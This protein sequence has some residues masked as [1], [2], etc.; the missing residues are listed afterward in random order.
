MV[1]EG[2]QS[3]FG[4]RQLFSDAGVLSR[5]CAQAY[6]GGH[7]VV[8]IDDVYTHDGQVRKS[9]VDSQIRDELFAS[10][11]PIYKERT[12][13]APDYKNNEMWVCFVSLDN[14]SDAFVDKAFVWNWRTNT[15]SKRDIPNLSYIGWGTTDTTDSSDWVSS[16][17]W[18][19][20]SEPWNSPIRQQMLFADVNNSK[21]YLQ[22]DTN[23][24]DG[25]NFKS[26]AAKEDMSLGTS[27]TKSVSKLIPRVSGTGNVNFYVGHK[28]VPN[29]ATT[30]KGPY[31]FTPGTHSEISVRATG[32]Y[33]GV[34]IETEDNN[35]WALDNLEVHWSTSGN[36][37]KGV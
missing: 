15:W 16:G 19:D 3:I 36:R 31:I 10:L 5:N 13:V 25:S 1:Y 6:E 24:F 18:A 37:G 7:F 35:S 2:G 28:F 8:G 29:E 30:W 32:N 23:Q 33:I 14:D 21:I 11:H 22:G 34:K 9:V 12:F 27:M 4:F 26:W 17:T 20:Q